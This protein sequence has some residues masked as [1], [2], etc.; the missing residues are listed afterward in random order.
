MKFTNLFKKELKELL[1]VQVLVSMIVTMLV[2]I[3][4]GNSFGGIIEDTVEEASEM[5]ICDRDNT[6]FTKQ[7]IKALTVSEI[8]ENTGLPLKYDDSLVTLVDIPTDNYIE[9]FKRLDINSVIIIPKGFSDKIAAGEK[10]ELINISRMTSGATLSNISMND[11]AVGSIREAIKQSYIVEHGISLEE[12]GTAESLV[13]VQ[14]KTI[15]ADRSADV[16]S[17]TIASLTSMQNMFLPIVVYILLMFSSQMIISAISTE[18]IDK[19]LETLFSA[20]VSRMSVLCAKMLAAAVIAALNA[21]AYMIG[22][23]YMMKG[24]TTGMT[25]GM[26]SEGSDAILQQLGLHLSVGDYALV[27][28]QLFLTILIALS[29]SLVLGALAKDAKAA[30]SLTMPIMF[31]AM[32]PYILSM[33]I[34]IKSLPAVVRYIVYAIPFTHTFTACDNIMFGN[35]KLYFGGMIYQMVLLVICL[36]LAVKVFTTDRIFTMT[37]DPSRKR[38]SKKGFKSDAHDGQTD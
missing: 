25:T 31:L 8:D 36:T 21:V 19:T 3:F 12:L 1:T 2:L 20:P 14:D 22:F 30:Q 11:A 24:M 5:T 10:A 32:I 13:T 28:I 35:M 27:G 18:K 23:N 29:V 16:S 37:I 15:V 26:T 34:D 33:I 4:V 17:A 38:K 6:P 9:E 7:L